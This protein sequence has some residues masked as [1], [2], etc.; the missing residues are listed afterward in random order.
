MAAGMMCYHRPTMTDSTRRARKS[1]DTERASK[2]EVPR[3]G[4]PIDCA[5]HHSAAIGPRALLL[6]AALAL[7]ARLAHDASTAHMPLTERLV[8]DAAGYYDWAC[9]IADGDWIGSQSFYQAP[10]YPYVLAIG[11]SIL[12]KGVWIVRLLQA[13]FGVA[14]ACFLSIA[15]ARLFGRIPGI[16][17][18]VMLALYAPAIF[19]DGIVQKTSLAALLLCMLLAAM[20]W[21]VRVGRG[22]AG[23]AVGVCVALMALT[24][25][26]ALLWIP[27]L[28]L[29]IPFARRRAARGRLIAI[30]AFASG[31]AL[32]LLPVGIRNYVAAGEFSVTTVQA[33]PNF[34]I[35]NSE[36]AD[37]RYRPLV[38]GHET[39]AFERADAILLAQR[40]VGRELSSKEVSTYWMSR[41]LDDIRQDPVR[42]MG[43]LA[44]KTVM[45][46]NRYEIADV[47]SLYISAEFS[48][49]V[50]WLDA[51]WNFG[52]LVPMAVAG[53]VLTWQDRRRLWV[54]Y[55]LIVSMVGAVVA[56]FVLARYRFPL[57]PL[58][59]PFAA[60]GV[61]TLYHRIRDWKGSPPELRRSLY[62]A[63]GL[64]CATAIF[65]NQRGPDEGRLDAMAF[66]NLGVAAAERSDELAATGESAAAKR[67][68][69]MAQ[70]QFTLAV[71]ANPSSPEA[72]V[73]LGQALVRGGRA[74]E[75]LVHYDAA[76][77]VDPDLAVAHF[78]RGQTL[79][80]VGRL[81]EAASAYRR[82]VQLGVEPVAPMASEALERLSEH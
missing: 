26:N 34:Y 52:V 53:I 78:L 18:G 58:I 23:A 55:A 9:R 46:V 76:I 54:Y 30:G 66:M 22:A 20:S 80:M 69:A 79:E 25:E 7:F 6:I 60:I 62:W 21:H 14:S 5:D 82:V 61:V 33:G 8:G 12:G 1:E 51:V 57:V 74:A 28:W 81:A 2:A 13:C 36:H 64:A 4:T 42:W 44:R 40:A 49:I 37:G 41:A 65:V 47:E 39:P 56:F 15:T 31:V 71:R 50:R 32:I 59:I 70:R 35:G 72:R 11:L 10:L 24:R 38:R 63:L 3:R 16:L 48:P 17:A 29:W 27:L 73:N 68:F 19:F 45:V 77:D 43:L 75:A 67:Y